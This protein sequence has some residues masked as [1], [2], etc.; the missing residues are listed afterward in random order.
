MSN[1]F[2]STDAFKGFVKGPFD[3][4]LHRLIEHIWQQR[5]SSQA[6]LQYEFSLTKYSKREIQEF[7]YPNGSIAP[8]PSILHI[9]QRPPRI[10]HNRMYRKS[11]QAH[12]RNTLE[13]SPLRHD[14]PIIFE[15]RYMTRFERDC[16]RTRIVVSGVGGADRAHAWL[17]GM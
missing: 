2:W 5:Y 4:R 6:E 15:G 9:L 16:A 1:S 8:N 7:T 13:H 17:A 3:G 10:S 14:A 11:R 12:T